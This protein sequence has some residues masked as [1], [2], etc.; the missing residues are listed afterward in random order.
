MVV[1]TI[2]IL[3]DT[4]FKSK[5]KTFCIELFNILSINFEGKLVQNTCWWKDIMNFFLIDKQQKL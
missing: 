5:F 3:K 2:I 4:A 1:F